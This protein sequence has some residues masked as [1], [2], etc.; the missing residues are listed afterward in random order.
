MSKQLKH[1]ESTKLFYSE[2]LYK[3]VFRNELNNIFRSELQKK[4]KLSY[5]RS[6]LDS[7]T[8]QYR[9]NL[10]LHKKAWRTDVSV[11]MTDYFDAMTVYTTLKKSNKLFLLD[12]GLFVPIALFLCSFR[13]TVAILLKSKQDGHGQ[14]ISV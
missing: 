7:L 6:Q 5:A 10:P 14:S 1:F 8:E 13:K 11:E 2:Y 3:L 12:I 4:E 9:N